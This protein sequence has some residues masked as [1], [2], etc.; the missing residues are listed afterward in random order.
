MHDRSLLC[1]VEGDLKLI[2]RLKKDNRNTPGG[3][4]V[5]PGN[6]LRGASLAAAGAETVEL[7]AVGLDR[8]A[9]PCGHL[10]LEALDVAVLELHNLSAAGANEVI[11]VAFVRDVVVLRLSAEVPGLSQTRFAEE[12]QR[13]VNGRQSQVRIFASQLVVH[14]F[15]RDVL[16]LEKCVEDQFT[17]ACELQLMFPEV[18]LQD[19]HFFGMFGHCDQTEPFQVGN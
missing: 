6:K 8:K 15:S 5:I 14:C 2:N 4:R 16:L 11:V 10:F 3:Q 13:A 19:S 12:V 9:V 17:L 18:L 7:K 1:E